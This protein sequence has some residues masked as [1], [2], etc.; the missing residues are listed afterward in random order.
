MWTGSSGPFRPQQPAQHSAWPVAAGSSQPS[1]VPAGPSTNPL[2]NG[3]P[4]ANPV[5]HAV[6][7]R[8]AVQDGF[9]VDGIPE[10]PKSFPELEAMSLRDLR[11]L[12]DENAKFE[13]FLSK[14]K[15]Q[16]M[17]EELVASVRA[18]V[19]STER[20]HME[21][22]AMTDNVGDED[23]LD[24]LRQSIKEMESEVS[25]LSKVKDEWLELNSPERLM[26]RLQLAM[27]E[28]EINSTKMEKDMLSSSMNFDAFL[29]QYI[30]C[31]KKYHERSLK[32]EQLKLEA[33]KKSF[34]R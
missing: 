21:I 14:H 1:S 17:V 12:H 15:H 6:D 20:E 27:R 25:E 2:G 31:R 5:T 19:D 23:E 32:L 7:H 29:V 30:A 9:G 4:S 33:K 10:P 34:N 13:D 22:T 24:Q 18:G 28:S 16:C 3:V 8:G 11:L 26:E